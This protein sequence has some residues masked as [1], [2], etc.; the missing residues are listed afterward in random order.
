MV[1]RELG[2]LSASLVM[3]LETFWLEDIASG[4]LAVHPSSPLATTAT[5]SKDPQ[6]KARRMALALLKGPLLADRVE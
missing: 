2:P 4:A 6:L 1:L 5:Q 3:D